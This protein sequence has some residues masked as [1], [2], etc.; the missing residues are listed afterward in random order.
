MATF[1]A[2]NFAVIPFRGRCFSLFLFTILRCF[3]GPDLLS[4]ERKKKKHCRES[5][6][7]MKIWVNIILKKT[8]GSRVAL[9]KDFLLIIRRTAHRMWLNLK[10]LFMQ[11]KLDKVIELLHVAITA[12]V[13][14]VSRRRLCLRLVSNVTFL[15][16][17]QPG[18][19]SAHLTESLAFV[20][21][22]IITLRYLLPRLFPR[23]QKISDGTRRKTKKCCNHVLNASWKHEA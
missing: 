21:S 23:N 8:N 14:T 9:W 3:C 15:C 5:Q 16:G 19:G 20:R 18:G 17:A 12:V 10:M 7:I 4:S 11:H 22:R 2:S 1:V 6:Y 13:L